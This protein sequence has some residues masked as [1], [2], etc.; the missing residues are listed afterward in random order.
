M[1]TLL[2][3]A[4]P[5]GGALAGLGGMIQLAGAEF[6]LRPGVL[7]SYGYVGFL[8]SWLARHRPLPSCCR[9]GRAVRDRDRRRQPA[10]RLRLPA[11]SVNMLMA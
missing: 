2:L 10:D 8:A 5:V 3:S 1:G 11:A 9:L 7:A 6:K 4:M